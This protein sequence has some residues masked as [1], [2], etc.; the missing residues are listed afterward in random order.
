MQTS[1]VS[2]IVPCY[3]LAHL[4]SDCIVS[5]LSQTYGNFEVLV[6]DDCSPDNTAEIAA[7]FGDPRVIHI[8]NETNLGHLRNYNK[9]I[10][11]ARGRYVWLI[12][13]DDYLGR[14]YVLERYVRLLDA[15]PRVGYVFCPGFAVG[16]QPDSPVAEWVATGQAIHGR[17]DRIF[18]GH[19]LA[20]ALVNGN[21]IIAASGLVRR[22]CYDRVSVFP[23]DMPWA[24]D[25]YLWCLFALYFD[26]GYFAEPM[27]CYREHDL[28][29]TN[30]LW[31]GE[32]ESCCEEDIA[33]PWALK[34]KADSLGLRGVSRSCLEALASIYC[35]SLLSKRYGMSTP[36]IDMEDFQRSVS[37]NAANEAE[38]DLLVALTF[39]A[40]GSEHFLQGRRPLAKEF[41]GRAR[42]K[43]PWLMKIW[44]KSFLLS[45]GRPGDFLWRWLK[46]ET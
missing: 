40:M 3:K 17:R 29:M 46:G 34:S 25:W 5:I 28:S 7:T 43:H 39:A 6:M 31:Q 19:H 23:L 15:H 13:A 36:A 20:K 18:R 16:V 26:V 11:L 41:F 4:L 27:V 12:S 2:F 10:S 22:E 35:R 21:T 38:R 9:G 32:V 14:Q 24:G 42:Q 33:I 1:T 45:L 30:K 44:A 37:A 8:R